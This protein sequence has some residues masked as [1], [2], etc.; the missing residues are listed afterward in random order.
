[1]PPFAVLKAEARVQQIPLSA[2]FVQLIAQPVTQPRDNFINNF[3]RFL[4]TQCGD[5][6]FAD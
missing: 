6:F 4:R 5:C 1:M 3:Q 2:R